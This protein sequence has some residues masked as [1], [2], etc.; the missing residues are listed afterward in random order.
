MIIMKAKRRRGQEA[1]RLVRLAIVLLAF[2]S[3]A[4]A[5]TDVAPAPSVLEQIGATVT[6]P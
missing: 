5:Q 2:A 1:K 6:F 3:P 4:R